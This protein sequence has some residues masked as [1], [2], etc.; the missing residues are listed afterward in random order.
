MSD[1]LDGKKDLETELWGV[2]ETLSDL[3]DE[4]ERARLKIQALGMLLKIRVSGDKGKTPDEDT[5]DDQAL[6]KA[7]EAVNN[8]KARR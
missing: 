3:E 5:V 7:R 4:G 2:Y 1:S 8:G 6:A